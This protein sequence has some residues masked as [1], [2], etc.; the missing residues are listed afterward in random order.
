M[1]EDRRL[2]LGG[3]SKPVGFLGHDRMWLSHSTP[4]YCQY[5]S[6]PQPLQQ[7]TEQGKG[8]E[9]KRM[10]RI[11]KQACKMEE[12][13][14]DAYECVTWLPFGQFPCLQEKYLI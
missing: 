8:W 3:S 10:M 2:P 1:W 12:M 11:V 5:P 14:A 9:G 7:G 13:A 4:H 6:H